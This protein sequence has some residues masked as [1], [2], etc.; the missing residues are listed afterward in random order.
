MKPDRQR[1]SVHFQ[2]QPMKRLLVLLVTMG[3]CVASAPAQ[4]LTAVLKDEGDWVSRYRTLI[5]LLSRPPSTGERLELVVGTMDVSDLCILHGDTL[6]YIPDPV[7]LPFG[8]STVVLSVATA[9]ET[10]KPAGSYSINVL[11]AGTLERGAI[12]PSISLANKGQPAEGHFPDGP[13]GGRQNFQELNGQISLK[14]EAERSGFRGSLGFTLVGVSFRQEALRFSEKREDAAKIDLSSYLLETRFG[15]SALSVGHLSHGR[16]RHLLSGFGSRGIAASSVIGSIADVSA[17]VL[18]ASNI[19]GWDNLAGLD[20][21]RHRIYSGTLG[22]EILPAAPGSIRIEASYVQASQLPISN[23]N[24]GQIT[25]AEQSRGGA[26]RLQLADPGHIVTVDA[27]VA[28]A[29]FTNPVDP[30]ISGQFGAVQTEPTTRWARYADVTWNAIRDLSLLNLL[31]TRLTL[32]YRHE[33]VDPLYRVVGAAV[34]S[35]ILS[36]TYEAHGGLG[37]LQV[38]VTHLLSEDNLADLPSVL[39]TKTRQTG[40]TSSF[41]PGL[42]AGLFPSWTPMLSYGLNVTHQYGTGIPIN[43]DMTAIRVPDQVTTSHSAAVEWQLNGVR[44]GFRETRTVQDNRQPG[45]EDADAV[46]ETQTVSISISALSEMAIN[47]DGSLE[48]LEN[49]ETAT[50]LRTRRIGLGLSMLLFAG[51]NTNVNG[52]LSKSGDN[53]GSSGQTQGSFS[54]EG[55][56]AFDLSRSFVFNWRGQIFVRYAWNEAVSTNSL[57]DLHSR[58]RA[59][60]ITTGISLNLF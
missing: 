40:L 49:K 47:L 60:V 25:D 36:N 15:A 29:R 3:I 38:D 53:I 44:T 16:E 48:S 54:L 51:L 28:K 14:M 4:D 46:S 30:F 39:K 21:P 41:V 35:D 43:S 56:Y 18:N 24:Q 26:V 55:S 6:L 17:T 8:Q 10:W 59:W 34:R 45:R 20:D 31:P 22:V 57:F 9:D 52:T 58:T 5:F 33:H 19:V 7:P 27:G 37:P 32:G 23:F 50:T 2:R 11:T 13:G 42:L 12:T 1:D